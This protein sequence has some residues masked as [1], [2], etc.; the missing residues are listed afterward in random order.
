[1]VNLANCKRIAK[2]FL[3]KIFSFKKLVIR[4]FA[5]RVYVSSVDGVVWSILSLRLLVN[6]STWPEWK[7][8]WE[9]TIFEYF[10]CQLVCRQT[11]HTHVNHWCS[12][13]YRDDRNYF[14]SN[15][16]MLCNFNSILGIHQNIIHQF[17][18]WAISPKFSPSKI[19]HYTVTWLNFWVCQ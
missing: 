18:L 9:N 3:S 5:V 15:E 4:I 11:K 14:V 6:S 16:G 1:L 2:I 17:L 13:W 8:E 12:M 10:F 19:L 7:I